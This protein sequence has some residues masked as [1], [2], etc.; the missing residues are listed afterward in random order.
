M[1]YVKI[2]S[3]KSVCVCA[4]LCVCVYIYI[5]PNVI[6]FIRPS[7]PEQPHGAEWLRHKASQRGRIMDLGVLAAGT[8]L[9]L[10]PGGAQG[11]LGGGALHI[12]GQ[13]SY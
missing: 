10:D 12:E 8:W 11:G 7:N 13:K 3:T 9:L 2:S 4:C 5:G 1:R 6:W